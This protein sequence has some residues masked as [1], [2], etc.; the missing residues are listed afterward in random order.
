MNN[1]AIRR[2]KDIVAFKQG[3]LPAVAFNAQNFEMAE[4]SDELWSDLQETS[5][6]EAVYPTKLNSEQ[7][8]QS[9]QNQ[10]RKAELEEWNSSP[11]DLSA[12]LSPVPLRVKSLTINVTQIC[13]LHCHYCAAGGDGTYGDPIRQ[14]SIE[15]TLP[16]IKFF[17]EQL[18]PTDSFHIIFLGG[19]PLLY[20][21]AISAIAE[22][23]QNL[24]QAKG[25]DFKTSFRIITNGT[26]IN[27]NFTTLMR[28]IR[29]T[30]TLSL[31]GDP[32]TNDRARPQKNGSSSSA[33]A[34]AGLK[35][36]LEN[37][38]VFPHVTI[39]SVF[40]K[41]NLD[42]IKAYEYFKNMPID[43]ME[44]TLDI[45]EKDPQVNQHFTDQMIQIA[46]KAYQLGGET[47]LKRISL[48]NGY[49]QAFDDL[50]LRPNHCSAGK[51]QLSLDS[52]N[53]IFS[54]PLEVSYKSNQVGETVSLDYEKLSDL[55]RPLIE[56]NQ[57][58][59][60]WAR[61]ICGGGCM[62]GHRS[63][64]GNSHQKHL[65]YCKRTRSLISEAIM[66]YKLN[67][68]LTASEVEN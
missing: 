61:F 36:L 65:T 35:I 38:E 45:A 51:G 68:V 52:K 64:T 37:R 39:H 12:A 23:T 49:F 66:L 54:C 63:T 57:C 29:P 56:L 55:Q 24:G 50:I 60:C 17:I 1:T 14:I 59:N 4:I 11:P 5:F 7:E 42:V 22:Y 6:Q 28:N 43:Q 32:E 18:S 31:D 30:I 21:E 8:K 47:E 53:R 33:A 26:L 16:Q 58:Q 27:S 2:Y 41:Q 9:P 48:F 20:P 40:T 46:R 67:R 3:L 19:E 10:D 13:N 62:F 44:F 25:P 15:K 34:L